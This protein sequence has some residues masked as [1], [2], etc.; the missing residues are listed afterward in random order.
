MRAAREI[1][2]MCCCVLDDGGED[3]KY[4]HVVS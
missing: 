3:E 2:G 1:I 4:S